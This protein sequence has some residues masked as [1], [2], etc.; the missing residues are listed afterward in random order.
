[1]S[2]GAQVTGL[3]TMPASERFTR[4]TCI[5]CSATAMFRCSTPTPPIRAMAMA[6]RASVTVSIAL[7]TN[8]VRSV[9]RR[10]SRV[11]VS[12]SEGMTSLG[13]GSSSTSS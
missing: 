9:I 5:T 4:S 12:T 3:F 1:M 7:D 8:G 10:V 2:S 6:I 11:E 13:A